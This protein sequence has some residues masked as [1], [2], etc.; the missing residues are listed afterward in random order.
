M[1][2]VGTEPLLRGIAIGPCAM[3]RHRLM[4]SKRVI[5]SAQNSLRGNIK[6]GIIERQKPCE[7][8]PTGSLP[9]RCSTKRCCALTSRLLKKSLTWPPLPLRGEAE[10]GNGPVGERRECEPRTPG[11]GW[12]G[13]TSRRA[14]KRSAEVFPAE[15][16]HQILV[17]TEREQDRLGEL[18]ET[19]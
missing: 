3:C 15:W 6:N 9:M 13:W 4:L 8:C 1:E 18:S 17:R 12:P 19:C 5:L 16:A 2:S 14:G 11:Q 7:Y 10:T